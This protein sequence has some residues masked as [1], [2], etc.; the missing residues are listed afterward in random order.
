MF[1]NICNV[2]LLHQLNLMDWKGFF[3]ASD[4]HWKIVIAIK[5]MVTV[6]FII[7]IIIIINHVLFQSFN[8]LIPKKN[9]WTRFWVRPN[10][11]PPI[12]FSVFQIGASKVLH[13]KIVYAF[14]IAP[15]LSKY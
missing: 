13:T 14:L 3:K 9:R 6:Y 7:I 2:C 15:I 5:L 8:P 12:A 4:K 10:H 11:Y 1:H